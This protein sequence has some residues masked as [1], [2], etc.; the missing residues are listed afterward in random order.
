MIRSRRPPL[1]LAVAIAVAGSSALTVL[2]AHG[3]NVTAHVRTDSV[4]V[5]ERFMLVVTSERPVWA[6]SVF[7][8]PP[9]DTSGEVLQAADVLLLKAILDSSTNPSEST[10]DSVIYEATTFALDTATVGPLTVG[11]VS[12]QDTFQVSTA[13][14]LLPVR[15]VV[16]DDAE[17]IRDL[18]PIAEFPTPV[19]PWLVFLALL[20]IATA[21]FLYWYRRSPEIISLIR[22]ESVERMAPL[23]EATE[24]LD[25]LEQ[26]NVETD[27]SKKVFFVELSDTL[28]T[29]IARRLGPPALESTSREVTE[30]LRVLGDAGEA[31]ES[32][33]TPATRVLETSDL[34]KFAEI[35]PTRERCLASIVEVREIL[36][37]VEGF[38]EPE[39]DPGEEEPVNITDDL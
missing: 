28:R 16:P 6:R 32:M 12:D 14:F 37:Q 31:P 39:T 13:P 9:A 34:A 5:G 19:W 30:A 33:V 4:S 24:R 7:P 35:F 20:I 36:T 18:M 8:S 23:D 2:P 25:A 26:A 22:D 10:V 3:Q 17:D 29:Y 11:I 15:S 1:L 27:A 38:L 21:A